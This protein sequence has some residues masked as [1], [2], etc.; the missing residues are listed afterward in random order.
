MNLVINTTIAATAY[1]KVSGKQGFL[2][3]RSTR[4]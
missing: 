1:K 2:Q 4:K 3:V